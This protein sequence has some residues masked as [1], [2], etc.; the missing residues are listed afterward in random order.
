[1]DKRIE[2]CIKKEQVDEIVRRI[3]YQYQKYLKF[4]KS[5]DYQDLFLEEYEPHKKQHS[6]SW[7]ISSAFPSGKTICGD[8]FIS[9]LKYEG[10]HTRPVLSNDKL[11][12]H[13]LNKTTDFH[14]KYL[15]KRYLYNK[16]NFSND[17]IFIYIK[18]F[19]DKDKNRLT[20]I[21]LCLPDENGNLV[22]EELLLNKKD[23]L[24]FAA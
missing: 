22:Y 21:S 18:F 5:K 20:K 24:Q 10:G 9:R 7:A 2:K 8:L 19:V 14:S 1:M 16:N 4:I 13:I 11:E 23:I 12:L 6:I 15:K 17:K 3:L